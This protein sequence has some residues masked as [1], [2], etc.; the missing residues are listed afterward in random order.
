M[1]EWTKNWAKKTEEAFFTTPF[2]DIRLN[3][4]LRKLQQHKE[5]G[6]ETIRW[7]FL[8]GIMFHFFVRRHWSWTK[9]L[10]VLIVMEIIGCQAYVLVCSW[11]SQNYMHTYLCGS[12][13][14]ITSRW[15]MAVEM[16]PWDGDGI[17][18]TLKLLPFLW[19]SDHCKGER[20]GDR[21]VSNDISEVA[22][23]SPLTRKE[24]LI[25]HV[26]LKDWGQQ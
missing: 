21:M 6:F 5:E 22:T 16:G 23:K 3:S 2:K 9:N 4:L 19:P 25:I 20:L 15:Y 13:F 11:S 1:W 17:P 24:V 14:D 26:A 8:V 7:T 10:I 12:V 18:G